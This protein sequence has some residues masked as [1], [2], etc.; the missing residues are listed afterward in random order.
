MYAPWLD[1]GELIR[2][3]HFY[4]SSM[5]SNRAAP[6][7]RHSKR[8]T[9]AA[10]FEERLANDTLKS[11]AQWAARSSQEIDDVDLESDVI[12]QGK[13][14]RT[15]NDDQ[16]SLDGCDPRRRP[17]RLSNRRGTR[18]SPSSVQL[19]C[20]RRLEL[21]ISRLYGAARSRRVIGKPRLPTRQRC[22]GHGRNVWRVVARKVALR[23]WEN[24]PRRFTTPVTLS[25]ATSQ[26]ALIGVRRP[27]REVTDAASLKRSRCTGEAVQIV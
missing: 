21:C 5:H 20:R 19:L 7:L 26:P 12:R 18:G 15:G 17:D 14:A 23:S 8:A 25:R 1:H 3:G 10:S 16:R 2:H 24:G 6:H 4:L 13:E 27:S 9:I 11:I 22:G